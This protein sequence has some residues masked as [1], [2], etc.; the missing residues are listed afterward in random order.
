MHEREGEAPSEPLSR[1]ATIQ[2][3]I[4]DKLCAGNSESVEAIMVQ[5]KVEVSQCK[6]AARTEPRPPGCVQ[7]LMC[8]YRIKHESIL[9]G[10][11]TF[12]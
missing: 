10:H 6:E 4:D 7:I 3:R 2:Q 9:N 12:G 8:K 1:V 5:C 11:K